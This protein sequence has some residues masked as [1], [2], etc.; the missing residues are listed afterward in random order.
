[1]VPLF[2]KHMKVARGTTRRLRRNAARS[3]WQQYQ[4][5]LDKGNIS[6]AAFMR[7]PFSGAPTKL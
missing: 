7:L 3:L 1:M 6:L 4:A 2:N 5:G